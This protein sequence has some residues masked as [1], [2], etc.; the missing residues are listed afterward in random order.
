MIINL[1]QHQ[2]TPDQKAAGV[3]DLEGEDLDKLKKQLTF[4]P[5]SPPNPGNMQFRAKVIALIA[6]R[7]GAKKAMIGG[8]MY[9]QGPLARALIRQG[10]T[11][12]WAFTERKVKEVT[13]PDGSV[14]KYGVFKH[15]GFVR[16]RHFE[17]SVRHVK[18]AMANTVE[19]QT[20][21]TLD[22]IE[23]LYS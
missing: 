11:P 19:P 10:I 20:W 12:L 5:P 16:D 22:D 17:I 2:S 13:Q 21:K 3:V 23:K 9:F 8:A 18:E 14:R 1:T 6:F 15:L 4:L 7:S